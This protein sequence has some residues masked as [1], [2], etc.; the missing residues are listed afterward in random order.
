MKKRI[1]SAIVMLLI[2]V[3]II[4]YGDFLFRLGVTIV[5]IFALKEILD[6][7]QS[8]GP[9]PN[10]VSLVS[11]ACLALIVLTNFDD[12]YSIMYGIT[13]RGVAILLLSLLALS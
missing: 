13:Y 3:P 7:K 8:H 4:W 11:I 12:S 10:T 1:L 9:I 2:T 6:L 5:S